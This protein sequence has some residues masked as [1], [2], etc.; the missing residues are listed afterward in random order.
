MDLPR[1]QKIGVRRMLECISLL[2][3]PLVP[4]TVDCLTHLHGSNEPLHSVHSAQPAGIIPAV[5]ISPYHSGF[6]RTIT[7]SITRSSVKSGFGG[8]QAN[9]GDESSGPSVLKSEASH[10]LH[11]YGD[12]KDTIVNT[13]MLQ[14]TRYYSRFSCIHSAVFGISSGIEILKSWNRYCIL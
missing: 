9:V 12:N 13:L 6:I 11:A 3:K 4:L 5:E 2:S 8:S 10:C 14:Y 7:D 1:L